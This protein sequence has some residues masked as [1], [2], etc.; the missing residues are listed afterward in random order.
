MNC[1]LRMILLCFAVLLFAVSTRTVAQEPPAP[2]PPA[3]VAGN[4]T[5]YSKGAN[6]RTATQFIQLKQ[7]GTVLTGHF[8]GPYQSGGLEGTINEQHI[9]FRTKTRSVLTFRGRVEG[10]RVQGT[11]Q[12][13]TIQ[14]TFHSHAGTGEWQAVRAQ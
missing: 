5:I 10:P 2:A 8:K 14:G 11:V 1:R 3:F 7:N 12:G 13:A 9:V 4:W 6:G